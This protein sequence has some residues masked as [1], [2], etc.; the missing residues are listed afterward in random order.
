M[1]FFLKKKIKT[2]GQQKTKGWIHDDERKSICIIKFRNV[3]ASATVKKSTHTH[4][5]TLRI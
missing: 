5:C 4:I 2:I 3:A 1:E